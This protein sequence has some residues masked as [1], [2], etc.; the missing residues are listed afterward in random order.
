M[1]RLKDKYKNDV[2]PQMMKDFNYSS[3]MQVPKIEKVVVNM[4]VGDAIQNSKL[5]DEAV[6]E[7]AAITGQAPVVTKAKKSIANFKL[8]EGMPIGCKV[9]LRSDKMY[10]FLD[11]LFNISLPRV[12]DFR[13]VSDTAFDGRGNY[14]LGIKEQIIFPEI[15]FDKVN[16][17]RGMDVVIVTT[18]QSN[19][20]AKALLEKLGMPFVK[21]N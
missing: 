7:M 20:E 8:R 12:R 16:R 5:L 17:T 1:A 18:A 11:K 10:E 2:V 14:T 13:G 6:A 21:N 3:V 19:D 15:D 9:T 4:G